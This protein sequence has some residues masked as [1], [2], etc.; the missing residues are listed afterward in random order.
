VLS[1]QRHAISDAVQAL[2]TKLSAKQVCAQVGRAL[3]SCARTEVA[4]R[5][6]KARMVENCM[7]AIFCLLWEIGK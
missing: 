4:A 2:L 7:A 1:P 3:R 6:R 5:P